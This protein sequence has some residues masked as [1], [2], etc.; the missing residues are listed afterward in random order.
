MLIDATIA[1]RGKVEVNPT[2]KLSRAIQGDKGILLTETNYAG[3]ES[4]SCARATRFAQ[5]GTSLK[6]KKQ[7]NPS[8]LDHDIE[9]RWERS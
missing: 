5:V 9:R 4:W 1:G 2:T 6:S 7:L 8:N 3:P